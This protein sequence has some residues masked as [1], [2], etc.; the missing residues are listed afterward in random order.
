MIMLVTV[1]VASNFIMII[2]PLPK[3]HSHGSGV[4]IMMVSVITYS[5]NSRSPAGPPTGRA[6][7]KQ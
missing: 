7:L 5:E 4:M 2:T 1:T 6:L 3:W